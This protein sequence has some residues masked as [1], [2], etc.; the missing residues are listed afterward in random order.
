MKKVVWFLLVILFALA[1]VAGTI[2][3]FYFGVQQSDV[4]CPEVTAGETQIT[5]NMYQWHL[6]VLNG[7]TYRSFEWDNT[8]NMQTVETQE[9]TLPLTVPAQTA[10]VRVS[11]S[12]GVCFEGTLEAYADY[13]FAKNGTYTVQI[14]TTTPIKTE[15]KAEGYGTMYYGFYVNVS[16]KPVLAI[17]TTSIKQGGVVAATVTGNLAQQPCT[18][19]TELGLATFTVIDGRQIA[20]IPIAYNREPG[21]WP[22]TVTCG[23]LSE[24]FTVT[25]I[26]ENFAEQQMYIEQEIADSTVNSAA[27]SAEYRQNIWPLYDYADTQTYW[28]GKFIKPV[29]G[30]RISTEYGLRRYVNGNTVP[31]RHSGIDFAVALGTPVYAPNAGKVLFSGFL[32]LSGNTVVIEHGAGIKSFFFHMDSLSVEKGQMVKQGDEVGKV[33]TTGYSTGPHLHYEV[34]IGNQSINPW[35]LFDGTSGI[36]YQP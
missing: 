34:K 23:E 26:H 5:A 19:E 4:V 24:T 22:I 15:G 6:P 16:V 17:N 25:V 21:D 28:S 1:I 2:G 7:L 10:T 32:Q 13:S 31:E 12:T 27:A 30:A 29:E 33:G 3:Y 35:D 20:F 11:D 14:L 18:V 36:F 8:A 9:I